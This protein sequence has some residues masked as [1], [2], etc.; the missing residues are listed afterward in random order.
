MKRTIILGMVL[1]VLL[2]VFALPLTASAQKGNPYDYMMQDDGGCPVLKFNSR[3]GQYL[4]YDNEGL[5]LAGI[6]SIKGTLG[7]LK[8][9]FKNSGYFGQFTCIEKT[10]AGYGS[11]IETSGWEI[12]ATIS[13]SNMTDNTGE[14]A[15]N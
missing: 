14:C 12:E 1:V 11:L 9:V 10:K 6:G 3:T 5:T 8:L 15:V 2:G 7:Q 4:F 13:D